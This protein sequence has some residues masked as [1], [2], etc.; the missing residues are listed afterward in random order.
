MK[1]A[2]M[3]ENNEVLT[4]IDKLLEELHAIFL[5]LTKASEQLFNEAEFDRASQIIS[6]IKAVNII[7]SKVITLREEWA[8]I[9]LSP[10][11]SENGKET[12]THTEPNQVLE[13]GLRTP[14]RAFHL[15]IL[16]ALIQ[17]GG[18]GSVQSILNRVHKMMRDQLNI[19]DYQ[20]LSSNPR[21]IRWENN[22][23]WARLKLVKQGYLASDSPRGVWAITDKGRERV[24]EVYPE[25]ELG[26]ADA[27]S[28]YH[29]EPF[30]FKDK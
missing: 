27:E 14:N 15:P 17:L 11:D 19:Y 18:A 29:T 22:A 26:K 16:K 1:G 7:K 2:V 4:S 5:E 30:D 13:P 10:V 23:Q 28:D 9:N 25:K 20:A 8:Q 12:L 24:S 3:I 6:Q 21:T